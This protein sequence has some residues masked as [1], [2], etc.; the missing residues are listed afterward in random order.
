MPIER[1]ARDKDG[2]TFEPMRV[3]WLRKHGITTVDATCDKCRHEGSIQIDGLPDALPVPDIG[4]RLRCSECGCR[5]IETRPSWGEYQAHG[6][7]R[8]G[9]ET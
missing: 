2:R 6:R 8:G 4:L 3:A 5:Q 1:R 7:A 9:S